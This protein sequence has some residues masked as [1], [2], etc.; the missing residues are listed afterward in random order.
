VLLSGAKRGAMR[1]VEAPP[2]GQGELSMRHRGN[3]HL[4]CRVP[5][6]IARQS[7][8]GERLIIS[9]RGSARKEGGV[10]DLS[11]D[12]ASSRRNI[13]ATTLGLMIVAE[14]NEERFAEGGGKAGL[15]KERFCCPGW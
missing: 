8:N 1:P 6:L 4:L 10:V 5:R 13:A 12:A 14:I 15:R 3:S 9:R 2:N 11:R 7:T